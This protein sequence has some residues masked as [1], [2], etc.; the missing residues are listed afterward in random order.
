MS[1]RGRAAELRADSDAHHVI[2]FDHSRRTMLIDHTRQC[3]VSTGPVMGKFQIK[4]H[5]QIAIGI[6]PSLN[7]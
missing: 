7:S 6:C 1:T 5:A 2:D 3:T 4:S